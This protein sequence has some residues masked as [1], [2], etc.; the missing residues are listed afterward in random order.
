MIE[1]RQSIRDHLGRP[2][3]LQDGFVADRRRHFRLRV[4]GDDEKVI[5]EVRSDGGDDLDFAHIPEQLQPD[6]GL[7]FR[8]WK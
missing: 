4:E 6:G 2:D 3:E 5:L 8:F 7:T 1:Q